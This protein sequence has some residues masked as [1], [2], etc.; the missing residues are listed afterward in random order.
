MKLRNLSYEN[1]KVNYNKKDK[2]I[3][4]GGRDVKRK[5]IGRSDNIYE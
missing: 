3:A 5:K 2:N 1:L 4:F